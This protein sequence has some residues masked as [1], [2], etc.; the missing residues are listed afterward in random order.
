MRLWALRDSLTHLSVL[1][2]DMPSTLQLDARQRELMRRSA[3]GR[4][5]VKQGA[6]PGWKALWWVTA[7]EREARE[8]AEAMGLM[9]SRK[10]N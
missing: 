8:Q 9:L 7:P 6:L 5:L 4:R 1:R 10:G 2:L 3:A